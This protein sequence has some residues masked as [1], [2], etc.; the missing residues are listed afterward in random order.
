MAPEP[1]AEPL[2]PA[3]LRRLTNAEM[4]NVITDLLGGQ[5][6]G[7]TRGFLP[8]PRVAGFDNDAAALVVSESKLDELASAAE[9]VG[10]ALAAP[11]NLERLAP[12]PGGV[13]PE[14]CART[15][16]AAAA[17]RAWGRPAA[18]EEITG[19]LAVYATGAQ[20]GGYRGG[21]AL[22]T[23]AILLSPSF[24]YRAELGDGTAAQGTTVLGEHE[25]ASALSFLLRGSRPDRPL[26]AA[27]QAA[28]LADPDER[29]RQVLRL[30]ATPAGR[31]QME[32]F[33]R[34]WLGLGDVGRINKD[35][36]ALPVFTPE[37]RRA[38][39]GT[40]TRFFQHV[41][42]EEETRLDPLFLADYAF[43]TPELGALYG[44]DF[45][46]ASAAGDRVTLGPERRGIL[47]SPAFLAQH[48]DV[49]HTSPVARGLVVRA[50]LLCQDVPPPPSDVPTPS[51][52][53][54]NGETRTTRQSFEAHAADP[55]C[56]SCHRL[57][58][59]LGFGF[60]A[61]DTLGRY[62]T[63]E[64][65]QPVDSR[66]QVLE[67][68]VD[69]P[70]QGPAALAHR[71]IRSAMFRRCFVEQ[72]YRYT[73][74]RPVAPADK[75]EIDYLAHRF[76]QSGHRIDALLVAIARRPTFILRRAP[77]PAAGEGMP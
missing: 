34:A 38:M 55:F 5:T 41:L 61:F 73:T 53:G 11:G 1:P 50:R 71:L 44:R 77:Q 8:D 70:F 51:P 18:E 23:E 4:E 14:A 32:R 31:A 25:I 40:L 64:A 76:E 6:L 21:I 12:C 60:E 62:R 27:A 42:E 49:G 72:L 17:R 9:R 39:D 75:A 20:T 48:A 36:G 29:E 7:A 3:R 47:S 67:T 45:P 15:F 46:E 52:K 10:A 35:L 22:C 58:D 65:G 33:L 66:G 16:I 59:S 69:G 74:G 57:I 37:L 43:V 2:L 19:L 13:A 26:V 28:S 63:E 68:D 54:E 24:A 30:L 56:A